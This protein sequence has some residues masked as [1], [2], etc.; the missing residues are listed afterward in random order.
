MTKG[1]VKREIKK[2]TNDCDS[3]EEMIDNIVKYIASNFKV[4]KRGGKNG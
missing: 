1:D 2:I 3:Y 4:K